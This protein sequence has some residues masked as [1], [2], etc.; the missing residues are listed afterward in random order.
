MTPCPTYEGNYTIGPSPVEML[1]IDLYREEMLMIVLYRGEIQMIVLHREEIQMIV[2][3]LEEIQMI[4]LH[5]AEMRM[6][7]PNPRVTPMIGYIPAMMET[8]HHPLSVI[9]SSFNCPRKRGLK[10]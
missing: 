10:S 5:P 6:I 7:V 1:M 3:Y 8:L 2:Q 4:V 9:N